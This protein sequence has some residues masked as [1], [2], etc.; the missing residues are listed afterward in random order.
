MEDECNINC[1]I[2]FVPFSKSYLIVGVM[3]FVLSLVFMAV[4]YLLLFRVVKRRTFVGTSQEE[5]QVRF[6]K[7]HELLKD[8]VKCVS[9]EVCFEGFFYE[10]LFCRFE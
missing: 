1:S 5:R 7:F 9:N 2:T 8:S 3:Y 4:F 6:N 10:Y